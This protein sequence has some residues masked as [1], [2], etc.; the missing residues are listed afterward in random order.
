MYAIQY[1]N[2]AFNVLHLYER[3]TF[4]LCLLME[5]EQIYEHRYEASHIRK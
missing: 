1:A 2:T 3:G 5:K 4:T